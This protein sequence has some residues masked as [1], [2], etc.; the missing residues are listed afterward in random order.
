M[1]IKMTKQELESKHE[2]YQ[3]N[4]D[5]WTLYETVWRSGK[6]L[7]EYSLYR[8]PRESSAN[9]DA[10]LRDGYAFNFGKSIIDIFSF[11]LN[12]KEPIRDMKG[13]A[14]DIQWQMDVDRIE[15]VV[16]ECGLS[17]VQESGRCLQLFDDGDVVWTLGKALAAPYAG[18][19]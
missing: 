13:L 8:H 10:R 19:R 12:E 18:E 17:A 16:L 4:I 5:N 15:H 14:D 6:K 11:Y 1:A 3:E 7:V 2:L 9:Y